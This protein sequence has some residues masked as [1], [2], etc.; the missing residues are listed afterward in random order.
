[1]ASSPGS[2]F[3]GPRAGAAA[4]H[5]G[6]AGAQDID[7]AVPDTRRVARV[8]YGSSE[9]LG[10]LQ[11]PLGSG[12]KHDPAIRGNALRPPSNA[13]VIFLRPTAGKENGGNVSSVMAGVARAMWSAGLA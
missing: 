7:Q 8:A 12:Q 3:A 2:G 9:L 13:A 6:D 10:Q 11:A 1:M 4:G 5:G